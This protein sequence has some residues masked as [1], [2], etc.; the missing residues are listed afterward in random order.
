M[1]NSRTWIWAWVIAEL[2]N[3]L[4]LSYLQNQ[5][6]LSNTAVARP[7]NATTDRKPGR[8]TCTHTCRASSTVLPSGGARII[9]KHFSLV[10]AEH[11][12]HSH[13]PLGLDNLTVL[14]R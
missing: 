1:A 14:P 9:P 10:G 7:P 12:F 3:L 8:L 2:V 5:G 4:T 11:A 13:I 6:K